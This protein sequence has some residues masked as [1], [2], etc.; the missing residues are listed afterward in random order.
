MWAPP[1]DYGAHIP[2]C[3]RVFLSFGYCFLLN[4]CAF[5]GE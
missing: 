5:P 4:I 2:F 3:M 1:L